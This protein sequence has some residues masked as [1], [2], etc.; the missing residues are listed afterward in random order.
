MNKRTSIVH[1]TKVIN[2]GL[3]S[4]FQIGDS[5]QITPFS[6][7]LAVQRQT[8]LFYG[9][10]GNF[11]TFPIFLRKLPMPNFY[12]P[13]KI[14]RYNKTPVIKVNNIKVTS[15]SAAGVY[16]I[17]STNSID[18]VTRIKHIRQLLEDP[19]ND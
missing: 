8:Q 3:G 18:A 13:I 15:V 10:E 12:T 5:G 1:S 7:A 6:L 9:T 4:V 19:D 16:H 2:V 17:G 11:N 14:N